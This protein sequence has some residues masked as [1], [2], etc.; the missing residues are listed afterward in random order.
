MFSVN[1]EVATVRNKVFKI[2]L[3]PFAELFGSYYN[4]V[5]GID[6]SILEIKDCVTIEKFH[7]Y[8]NQEIRGIALPNEI[9]RK[10]VVVTK[11]FAKEFPS[12]SKERAQDVLNYSLSCINTAEAMGEYL[13]SIVLDRNVE[14]LV[15]AAEDG[16]SAFTVMLLKR[17]G[18][19][20]SED[21]VKQAG[22]VVRQPRVK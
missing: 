5:S 3:G 20:V 17:A 2:S 12:V 18:I 15:V 9:A 16:S 6:M 7:K 13:R 10:L 22:K 1:R 8:A 14:K 21:K 19:N 11:D 4:S